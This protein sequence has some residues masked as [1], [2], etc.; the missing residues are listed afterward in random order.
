MRK[1]EL[2]SKGTIYSDQ[3]GPIEYT[4]FGAYAQ[5]V[6]KV[7]NDRIDLTASIRVDKHEFFDANFTPRIGALIA[8]DQNQNL[9]MSFQTGFRNPTNQ[10]QYIGLFAGDVTLLGTSPDNISRYN[11]TV[12]LNNGNPNTFT[13]DYVFNNAFT[14]GGAAANLQHVKAEKITSYDLGYRFKGKGLT[15]DISG[16][17]TNYTD[18]IGSTDA[19]V[20]ALTD[21][22]GNTATMSNYRQLG[23]YAIYQADSNSKEELRTYGLSGEVI[24]T[25][26]SNFVFNVIYDYNKLDYTPRT[27]ENFEAGYNTPEHNIKAG[28]LGNFDKLSFNVSSRYTS[29]YYY[30]ASFVDGMI[31]A[32]N[33]IDAQVS[34]D[35]PS[36]NAVIKVGGNNIGGDEYFSVL[37]GGKIG[38]VYYTAINFNF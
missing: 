13:G 10:D 29:E 30:E 12:L 1:T 9:R 26:S 4:E 28:L 19:Y 35:L 25:L 37:G 5:G 3:D 11:G 2:N 22:L 36:I 20:P 31:D 33:V 17:V 16:Y 18:K 24:K 23:A 14:Q 8:I 38:S 7:F 15:I 34:Y 32:R 21:L 27:S 6:K